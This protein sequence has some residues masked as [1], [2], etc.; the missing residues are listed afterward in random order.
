M[1]SSWFYG[2]KVS[3]PD[4]LSQ[5]TTVILLY[6]NTTSFPPLAHSLTS[7]SASNTAIVLRTYYPLFKFL[8]IKYYSYVTFFSFPTRFLQFCLLC[9]DYDLWHNIIYGVLVT[10]PGNII[11]GSITLFMESSQM[12]PAIEMNL[13]VFYQNND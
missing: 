5:I 12:N 3:R 7:P 6:L 10:S 8:Q 1:S 9:N 13:S 11:I 2:G 4:K